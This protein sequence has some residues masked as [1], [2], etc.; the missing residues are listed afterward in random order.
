MTITGARESARSAAPAPLGSA[1]RPNPAPATAS[2]V[3]CCHSLERLPRLR[4]TLGAL[5]EQT[6][7]PHEIIVVTD[8]NEELHSRLSSLA[9]VE[10]HRNEEARGLSGARNTGWRHSRADI[11]AFI[12]DDA[13][14]ESDWLAQLVKPLEEDAATMATSGWVVPAGGNVPGWYPK[15]LYWVFGCSWTGLEDRDE[16]RNPLGA[17]MAWRREVLTAIGGFAPAMGR[18]GQS[19][20]PSLPEPSRRLWRTTSLMSCEETLAGILAAARVGGAIR[21]VPTSVAHHYV[22]RERIG[23]GYLCRRCWGEGISKSLVRAL[24]GEPLGE[25]SRHLRRVSLAIARSL[26]DPRRWT[27][28]AYLSV[29]LAVT[30]AGYLYGTGLM[31]LEMLTGRSGFARGVVEE[32]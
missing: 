7:P 5:A 14:P 8:Y 3:V 12:D 1:S 26:T 19:A 6:R 13:L 22:P 15:E 21:Q 10:L 17:S 23:L 27:Q 4:E 18:A 24:G 20:E 29:G 30:V 25:E 32:R 16:I 11:V 31:R 28:G 2:V 9:A